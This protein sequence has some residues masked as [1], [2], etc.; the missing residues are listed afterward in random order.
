MQA[1][2]VG[3]GK[4]ANIRSGSSGGSDH[5]SRP[6]ATL[7]DPA[8]FGPPPR[9]VN[10]HGGAALP[11]QITP[12]R[13]GLGAPLSKAQVEAADR[14]VQSTEEAEL[15][16][17]SK[18][19][20]PPIPY[21]ANRTGLKTDHLPPP[22]LY[23]A[24]DGD[25]GNGQETG[26][27]RGPHKTI[28]SLPPRLPPRSNSSNLASPVAISPPPPPYDSVVEEPKPAA[29]KYINQGALDRLGK[30][31][32][33]VPGFG[34]GQSSSPA[35]TEP[36]RAASPPKTL[37]NELPSRFTRMNTTSISPQ[38]TN[39]PSQGATLAQKQAAFKTA[40]SFHKDPSSVS[41]SDAKSAATT[42][43]DFRE[44]HH[45]Q[46]TAGAQKANSWNKKYD[47]TGR[48]DRLLKEHALPAEER[49]QQ[50]QLPQ[51]ALQSQQ[52]PKDIAQTPHLG[53]RKPPPPPPPKKPSSMH[54]QAMEGQA[55]PPVPL[56]TK[57][58]FG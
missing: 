17:P 40:Q 36:S 1:G 47:I 34:I 20:L 42:A 58:S 22:P 3:K 31:G 46:I 54:G 56:G 18:P 14:A 29:N 27:A 25:N 33:S 24:G 55:P 10:Y 26:T 28:P 19:A 53:S 12:D 2:W 43:N 15:E 5:I 30:A 8:S 48:V 23:Q 21:R 50:Q 49:T 7:K 52:N 9:N 39:S 41:V 35:P 38:P 13:R 11:N 32:I 51:A 45:E 44:R 37:L 16:E 4:N 57:P 6:L